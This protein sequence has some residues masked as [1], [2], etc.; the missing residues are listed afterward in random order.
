MIALFH[1]QSGF[2]PAGK[3]HS[4]FQ[5][6]MPVKLSMLVMWREDEVVEL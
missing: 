5:V 4:T 3:I 1:R 6:S 2:I